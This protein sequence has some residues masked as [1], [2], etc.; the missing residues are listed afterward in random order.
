MNWLIPLDVKP[1]I[2]QMAIAV[3]GERRLVEVYRL[4]ALWSIHLYQYRAMIL[5]NGQELGVQ[6]GSVTVFP[7]ATT[8]EYR[9][10][11]RSV[12]AY[13]HFSFPETVGAAESIPAVQQMTGLKPS[14][15]EAIG[16]FP[17]QRL[18]AEVRLWDILWRLA[19]RAPHH[20][21]APIHP[22]VEQARQLIELRLGEDIYVTDL[23]RKVG[24]SQNHLARLFKAAT[25]QSM[26]AYIRARRVEQAAHLLQ[27][28]TLP[29]K[30]VAGAVG[31]PDLHLF[32][33]SIRR[34]FGVPPRRLRAN[35][36]RT[37]RRTP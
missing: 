8:L 28:S 9:Y 13:A 1:A 35:T 10:Q 31:I 21:L 7:P 24:L 30:A 12:H 22:A 34:A 6:P 27:H 36:G 11:G 32:N 19:T 2:A 17:T 20:A 33:K 23:A 14:F 29:I 5:V 25:G 26:A 15:E 37:S 18:R 16:W 4:P 3:H